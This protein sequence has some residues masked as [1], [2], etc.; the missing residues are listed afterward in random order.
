MGK[1]RW[2]LNKS[3]RMRLKAFIILLGVLLILILLLGKLVITLVHLWENRQRKFVPDIPTIER[4]SNVWIM[5]LQD[6]G[7]LVFQDGE[8]ILYPYGSIALKHRRGQAP[9]RRTYAPDPSAREQ[10]ADIVLADG[11][12]TDII[13]KTN[14][15]N[16][17]ILS[18]DNQG[19][20][21][22]GYG[23]IP[24]D[25]DYKGYR[26]YDSLAM[27]TVGDIFFG[28]NFTDLCIDHGRVCG[29]LLAKEEAM[30]YVRV[31]IKASDYSAALHSQPIL[32]C[33]TGYK[34]VYGNYEA[35]QEEHYEAG[36]EVVVGPDSG[37]ADGEGHHKELQPQPGDALIQGPDGAYENGRRNRCYQ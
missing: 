17:R 1:N 2:N 3:Q 35:L 32:T 29:V 34:V 9:A 31:L 15:I 28:Y 37:C 18:A 21:V 30:E 10:V 25:A 8:N 13:P 19:I 23:K 26:L 16:G 7:L 11:M 14:K 6:D 12:V 5:E 27:C 33:N 36:E 24:L 22:E 4:I 20:E